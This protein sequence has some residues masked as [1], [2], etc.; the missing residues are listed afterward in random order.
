[1]KSTLL[2]RTHVSTSYIIYPM[3]FKS[4]SVK[5]TEEELKHLE[6]PEKLMAFR[7]D[8]EYAMNVS[9]GRHAMS[10]EYLSRSSRAYIP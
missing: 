8:I 10:I 2:T 9:C 6:D 1:M 3:S 5:L 7:K 4:F